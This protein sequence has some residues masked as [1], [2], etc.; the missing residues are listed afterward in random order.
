M[1][2]FMKAFRVKRG[3]VL[4]I[5]GTF[6]FWKVMEFGR[7]DTADITLLNLKECQIPENYGNITSVVGDATNLKEYGDQQFRLAF[8]NSVIE[9]VGDFE[10]QKRMAKE[11][12]RVG[13]HCYLQT[14]NRYFPIE[15]HFLFPFFQFLPISIRTFLVKHWQLGNMPKGESRMEALNIAKSVRLLNKKELESLFP[16]VTIRKEKIGFLTKS[17]YLYF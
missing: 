1:K 7:L 8:S 12:V 5:G 6:E 17:F 4:D 15:P 2:S 11:M 10:A 14:P 13:K 3:G 16:N 9:H